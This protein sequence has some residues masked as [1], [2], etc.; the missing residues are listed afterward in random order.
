[1][2]TE[3]QGM[4]KD[5]IPKQLPRRHSR[6]MLSHFGKDLIVRF[7]NELPRRVVIPTVGA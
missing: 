1:M 3:Y 4:A 6:R 7:D 5:H 2:V